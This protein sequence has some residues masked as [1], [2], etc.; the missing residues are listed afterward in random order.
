MDSLPGDQSLL[1][2]TFKRTE[3]TPKVP[4][5]TTTSLPTEAVNGV[6]IVAFIPGVGMNLTPVA[7]EAPRKQLLFHTSEM[8]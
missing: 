5:E 1:S 8:A 4:D 7:A 3:P 6:P 2:V